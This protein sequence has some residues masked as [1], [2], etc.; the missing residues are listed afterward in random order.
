MYLGV[1]GSGIYTVDT[2]IHHHWFR[3]A[4]LWLSLKYK[5]RLGPQLSG[6]GAG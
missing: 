4:Y 6:N 3:S 1:S 5:G 2:L